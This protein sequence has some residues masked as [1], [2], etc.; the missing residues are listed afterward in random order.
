MNTLFIIRMKRGDKSV[1]I[2]SPA[3]KLAICG[4]SLMVK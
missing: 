1:S 3:V 4:I 2:D